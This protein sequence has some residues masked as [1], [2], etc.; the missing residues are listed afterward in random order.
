[1]G[2]EQSGVATGSAIAAREPGSDDKLRFEIAGR[3]YE[4]DGITK[5]Q[6]LETF[7]LAPL[8]DA[9]KGKNAAAKI[10]LNDFKCDTR[11]DLTEETGARYIAR[12]KA[13]C[14]ETEAAGATA[15]DAR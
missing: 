10:L 12:L 9:K 13:D 1:V 14:G 5:D 6:L 8:V 15:T 2:S 7:R 4:T 3:H 11:T